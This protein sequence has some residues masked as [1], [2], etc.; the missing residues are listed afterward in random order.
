MNSRKVHL[1]SRVVTGDFMTYLNGPAKPLLI[2]FFTLPFLYLV[3][4]M[5]KFNGFIGN[6]GVSVDYIFKK[7]KFRSNESTPLYW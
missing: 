2:I 5:G 6:D 3:E 4:K 1:K 7:D